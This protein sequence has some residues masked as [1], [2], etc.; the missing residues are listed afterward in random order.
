M[1]FSDYR[2]YCCIGDDVT[3]IF[4]VQIFQ[5]VKQQSYN[6]IQIL[7]S[8][9][10]QRPWFHFLRKRSVYFTGFSSPFPIFFKIFS[11]YLGGSNFLVGTNFLKWLVYFWSSSHSVFQYFNLKSRNSMSSLIRFQCVLYDLLVFF[12]VFLNSLKLWRWELVSGGTNSAE[13]LNYLLHLLYSIFKN[14]KVPNCIS[15]INF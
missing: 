9:K 1:S 11:N 13:Q 8:K 5:N 10:Q 4:I 6:K 3:V 15:L 7:Q 12:S 14:L 2:S